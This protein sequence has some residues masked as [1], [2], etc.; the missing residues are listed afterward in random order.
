MDYLIIGYGNTLRGDDGAGQR[1]AERVSDWNLTNARSLC[2]H[3]LTP[4]VAA[5]IA[6]AE[7][8]IFVDA[9]TPTEE[10]ITQV[11][12]TQLEAEET[13]SQWAHFQDPRSLLLLTQKLYGKTP[14]A[15][16]VGIPAEN[17]AF[18]ESLSTTTEAA[19][20]QALAE[21]HKLICDLTHTIGDAFAL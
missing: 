5:E 17:F 16:Q 9:L 14:I 20:E 15:Y 8:V 10:T 6:E 7:V 1:V 13:P 21:I 4:E 3:Q 12:I 2:L 18:G 19:V 11:Q